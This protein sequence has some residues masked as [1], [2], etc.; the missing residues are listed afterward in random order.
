[1]NVPYNATQAEV[2][3]GTNDN[4]FV[5]PSTLS[6]S[7]QWATKQATLVSATNIKTIN[8]TTILGSGDLAVQAVLVSGTSIKTIN[9]TSLLG[10]G[11]VAVQATLVSGT[12]IKT[13]NGSTILGSG[14]LTV[15]ASLVVGTTALTSGTIGRIL[16]EGTGNVL[17]ESANLFYD[18]T[19]SWQGLGTSTPKATL[20]VTTT[21]GT[22]IR[23]DYTI[24]LPY[25]GLWTGWNTGNSTL[26]SYT[27]AG[28]LGTIA[29]VPSS[30]QGSIIMGAVASSTISEKLGVLGNVVI[31]NTTV[32][33]GAAGYLEFNFNSKFGGNANNVSRITGNV[34]SGGGG[35]FLFQTASTS[36]GAYATKATFTRAGQLFIGGTTVPTAF[37]HLAAGTATANTAP[38]KYTSS[39]T[40][41]TGLLTT[42]ES[43]ANEF[44]TY[45]TWITTTGAARHKVW[46]G[47]RTNL[48]VLG[49]TA[50]TQ[51][52]NQISVVGDDGNTYYIPCSAANTPL[53]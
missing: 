12:N 51:L 19:N 41:L 49:L 18:S 45:G 46:H 5:T 16:F 39:G 17:Q 28:N 15:S 43:G 48:N 9:S 8:S 35:G 53:T 52:T 10:S 47:L 20:D 44:T 31:S 37:L 38:L 27:A 29:L 33:V 50:I 7:T 23:S 14:N 42:P 34:E 22:V 4:K 36:A 6:N 32:S 1:M 25:G 26:I 30:T 24:A 2:N 40:G 3:T 21:G 13:I 11:D